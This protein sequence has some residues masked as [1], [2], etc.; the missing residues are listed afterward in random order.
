MNFIWASE[1]KFR[2]SARHGPI[3]I[4]TLAGLNNIIFEGNA[5]VIFT[6]LIN[7]PPL[8]GGLRISLLDEPKVCEF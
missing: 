4:P 6:P 5:R 8:F 1:C 7:E 3:H 2:L